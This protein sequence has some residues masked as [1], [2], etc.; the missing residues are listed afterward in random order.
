MKLRLNL[1]LRAALLACYAIA[2]PIAST[3]FT[4]AFVL[5]PQAI[6]SDS[7]DT[8]A[9]IVAA[10]EEVSYDLGNVMYVGDSITHGGNCQSYRWNIHT[11]F[12]DNGLSYNSIGIMQGDWSAA[13]SPDGYGGVTY[14]N[15]H[16]SE[17]GGNS[18]AVAGA[19]DDSRDKFGDSN[20]TNW[21]GQSS[22]TADGTDYVLGD[23]M[24][25]T[26]PADI[27]ATLKVFSDDYV[28]ADGVSSEYVEG[29]P[30][31]FWMMIGTNDV[32]SN[33]NA[34]NGTQNITDLD[35]VADLYTNMQT[36]YDSVRENSDDCK[37]ILGTI[38]VWSSAKSWA[39][40]NDAGRQAIYAYNESLLAWAEAKNDENLII[41]DTSVGMVDVTLGIENYKGLA[42]MFYDGLHP[43][44]QGNLI[45]AANFAKGSGY[46]GGTAGQARKSE[47]EFALNFSKGGSTNFVDKANVESKG[48]T[49]VNTTVTSSSI[50]LGGNGQSSSLYYEWQEGEGL[51]NGATVD[52]NLTFGD[53]AANGWNTADDLNIIMGNSAYAGMLSIDEGYVSWDGTIIYSLDTST[54][55]YNF[56]LAWVNGQASA[57]LSTGFYLWLDD[58]LIGAGLQGTS[59]SYTDYDGV[60]F[61]YDGSG[62]VILNDLSI[63]GTASYAPTTDGLSNADNV[64][65]A[66]AD[67]PDGP[68]A[69]DLS[70]NADGSVVWTTQNFDADHIG[71]TTASGGDF[72][73]RGT[74]TPDALGGAVSLTIDAGDGTAN[75]IYANSSSYSGDVWAEIN[76]GAI[77]NS[78]AAWYAAHG[79]GSSGT[80]ASFVVNG[81]IFLKFTESATGSLVDANGNLTGN[82]A[83][84]LGAINGGTT[85]GSIYLEFS[86]ENLHLGNGYSGFGASVAGAYNSTINNDMHMVFNTGTFESAI[87]G[88]VITGTT[89]S[90]GGT[91]Y[92]NVN[93]GTFNGNIFGGGKVGSQGGNLP[94]AGTAGTTQV[95]IAGGTINA[96]VYGGG[97]GGTITGN[98]DVT[99]SGGTI[100]GDVYGGGTGGTITGNTSVTIDGSEVVL[101]DGTNWGNVSTGGSSGTISGS[102]TLTIKNVSDS[103]LVNGFDKFAGSLSSTNSTNSQINF[104]NVQLS[105]FSAE[106]SNFNT[107]YIGGN[108]QITLSNTAGTTVNSLVLDSNLSLT[109]AEN[110][111]FTMSN[112]GSVFVSYESCSIVNH[113]VFSFTDATNINPSDFGSLI[114]GNGTI[115]IAGT[116]DISNASLGGDA[117]ADF[118]ANSLILNDGLVLNISQSL[119]NGSYAIFGADAVTGLDSNITITGLTGSQFSRLVF[120]DA[121]GIL[122]LVLSDMGTLTWDDST[123]SFGSGDT[124]ISYLEIDASSTA[125]TV[126]LSKDVTGLNVGLQGDNGITISGHSLSATGSIVIDAS[127]ISI[128]EGGALAGEMSFTSS[129]FIDAGNIAITAT[130]ATTFDGTIGLNSLSGDISNASLAVTGDASFS[131]VVFD[132]STLSVSASS[133][134]TLSGNNELPAF[135]LAEGLTIAVTGGETSIGDGASSY[136]TSGSKAA[137]YNYEINLANGSLLSDNTQLWLA[138]TAAASDF[139]L[140]VSGDGTY[141]V[142]S[143]LVRSTDTG[144]YTISIEDGATMHVTNT[145]TASSSAYSGFVI[146]G[147]PSTKGESYINIGANS[148]FILDAGIINYSTGTGVINVDAGGTLTLNRGTLSYNRSTGTNTINLEGTMQ[149]GNTIADDGTAATSSANLSV[150]TVNL[151]DGASIYGTG[152]SFVSSSTAGSVFSTTTT[153][154]VYQSLTIA[155]SGT[156]NMGTASGSTLNLYTDLNQGDYSTTLN[157]TGGTLNLAGGATLDSITAATGTTLAISSD[158][159]AGSI[160]ADKLSVTSA[161]NL[162]LGAGSNITTL[163][164]NT[165]LISFTGSATVGSLN[166]GSSSYVTNLA[167]S[168][169]DTVVSVNGGAT[170]SAASV[171]KTLSGNYTLTLADGATYSENSKFY[172]N[173]ATMT[174]TG[175]GTYKQSMMILSATGGV[176]TTLNVGEDAVMEITSSATSSSNN[177][178][179]FWIS[180]SGT[181]RSDVTIDGTLIVNGMIVDRTGTG[182]ASAS[183]ITVNNGGTLQL[184]D[185]LYAD[186]VYTTGI[187]LTVESGGTLALGNQYNTTEYKSE[188]VATMKS[189]S[190]IKAMDSETNVYTTLTYADGASVTFDGKDNSLIMNRAVSGTNITANIEGNVSF[191]AGATLQAIDVA[192]DSTLALGG[193]VSISDS[194][195]LSSGASI[196]LGSITSLSFGED[197]SLVLNYELEYGTDY[198][199]FTGA[200]SSDFTSDFASITSTDFDSTAYEYSWSY[201]ASGNVN[202]SLSAI[203]SEVTWDESTGV[204]TL[205]DSSSSSDEFIF[206]ASDNT[207][208]KTPSIDTGSAGESG[209]TSTGAV[210]VTGESDVTISGDNDLASSDTITV[211]DGSSATN[212][213]VSTGVRAEGGIEVSSGSSIS[214]DTDGSI[215]GTDVNLAEGTSLTAG[216]ITVTAKEDGAGVVSDATTSIIKDAIASAE[217]AKSTV[218]VTGD[219][220][221]LTDSSICDESTLAVNSGTLEITGTSSISAETT[222]KDGASIV[223][224]VI[225]VDGTETGTSISYSD[226]G[227]LTADKLASAVISGA[228]IKVAE[229]PAAGGSLIAARTATYTGGILQNTTIQ[230]ASSIELAN[231]ANLKFDTV[232]LGADTTFTAAGNNEITFT[233]ENT[234]NA[235]DIAANGDNLSIGTTNA[236]DGTVM[237]AYTI[238]TFSDLT[239]SSNVTVE[240]YLSLVLS[241]DTDAF[242]AV[243]A[244]WSAG[245]LFAIIL[246]F[247]DVAA[248]DVDYSNLDGVTVYINAANGSGSYVLST[249]DCGTTSVDANG[250]LVV[251][252]PEPSTA[253]LS[254]M[255][256]AGLL[257]RRRRKA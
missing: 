242:A 131:D 159:T 217:V 50:Q 213:T 6:A 87:Y 56:R 203:D 223:A 3:L 173:N 33:W 200:S 81:N 199:I 220:G 241:L 249:V 68:S 196:D 198:T 185:G 11:I 10:T 253:T 250:N 35:C 133:T 257:A 45:F 165:G 148:T 163:T 176:A 207:S 179:G 239:A 149:L 125:Q 88:G 231:A 84:V 75:R 89:N 14:T 43:N 158:V 215:A 25:C 236:A 123:D 147:A 113:G 42:S 139:E 205:P 208:G 18:S 94:N 115:N 229:S 178:I 30:D 120:D 177:A 1:S 162:S 216:N 126:A 23:S 181:S 151:Y 222:I 26:S 140:V 129:S 117:L 32:N 168:G 166:T 92:I 19:A 96:N 183:S 170:T 157:V 8:A 83:T 69:S 156:I 85:N 224:G 174:V 29:S 244:S 175:D 246:D 248:V 20:I 98:T 234:I 160:T 255:A 107:M 7:D 251:T 124:T 5:T 105:N 238:T 95:N 145:Y 22:T 184:N 187:N 52:F 63:D 116:W 97:A 150:L 230:D 17:S 192:A 111:S 188:I 28:A 27:D 143:V 73:A 106:I 240:G 66:T 119:E 44:D 99:L 228:S 54:N 142:T 233:G 64:F 93:G 74:A 189:G 194:I 221:T 59:G 16:N 72:N 38:P 197:F 144:D 254:L 172:F 141:E 121:T 225:S 171:A 155:E 40:V 100:S 128:G 252:I 169:A 12:V 235:T 80:G 153:T 15:I 209:T 76:A 112:L 232:V 247:G 201:D 53:G 49:L 91:T 204:A 226:D 104:E 58:M 219:G 202:L 102:Q 161:A 118:N 180:G 67:N 154:N 110:S 109:I 34:W 31:V 4:G 39:S 132:N 60:T 136:A 135:T 186:S 164:Q 193:E 61:T 46:A 13:Q 36:I 48:I 2:A 211:G 90:I 210:V 21:M 101:H 9:A 146:S 227:A 41:V 206:D 138:S 51:S 114:S 130:T 86:A 245:D 78:S 65:I 55:D 182:M 70:W 62:N 191:A 79:C 82:G 237:D 152:V 134:L 195:T 77:A 122:S 127:Q 108:S 212:V 37:I 218:T 256:L 57:E 190:I 214:V 24:S 137:R 71:S 47:T 243:A 103:N 167:V